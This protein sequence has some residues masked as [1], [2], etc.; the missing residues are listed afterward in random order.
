MGAVNLKSKIQNR[1]DILYQSLDGNFFGR[2]LPKI[3]S[4]PYFRILAVSTQLLKM[5]QA[6]LSV[7]D[8]FTHQRQKSP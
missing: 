5:V 8:Y 7:T 2:T 3:H 1:I 4:K 6:V